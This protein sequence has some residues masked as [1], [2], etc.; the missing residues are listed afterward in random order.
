MRGNKAS[1]GLPLSLVVAAL[2]TVAPFT[3]DTYLPS[4]PDIGT[5]LSATHAQMQLTLSLYLFA[6]A[7]STLIYGP[8][9]DGFGRRRVIM[10]ALLIYVAASIGCALTA[11]IDQ[12]ILLRIGQGLS[13]SAGMVIGRAMVRDVYHGAD[14]QR[15]MS[16]VMLLFAIAPA[17]A[18]VIGGWLHDMFGW[19]SVFLFLALVAAALFL[20]IWLGTG[21]TLAAEKRQS[22]HPLVIA[23]S[24][25]RAL[26]HRHFLALVFCFALMFSG[27]FIYVAGAPVVIYVFLGLGVNDFWM[28]FVPCVAAIMIGAQL[29]SWLAGR[30]SA[31]RTVRIGLGLLLAASMVNLMQSLW[32]AATPLSVIAP[33]ALY[34]LGMALTMPNLNVMALDCFPHNRG[35]ASAMQSF[36]QMAFTALVVGAVVPLVTVSLTMM[37]LCMF[38]LSLIACLFWILRGGESEAVA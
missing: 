11:T 7:T 35:M 8:L 29:S 37:T 24:Y 22:I 16:R 20:M 12:L 25:A 27:F 21:E 31:T 5:E 28:L 2:A 14:A 33:L 32:L 34:V 10:A 23:R 30:F 38:G 17:I 13:A 15:V 18:P 4:F 6:A 9:S 26:R 1:V 3:I 36:V 19:H